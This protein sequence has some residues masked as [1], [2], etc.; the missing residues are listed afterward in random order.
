MNKK[1]LSFITAL[2]F[3]FACFPCG[4]GAA[5]TIS[6]YD[7]DYA[8]SAFVLKSIC[9]DFP[10]ENGE[11]TTRAEFVAAVSMVLNMPNKTV[12]QTGF[13]D[14]GA[15]NAYASHISYARDLGL[16]SSVDLFYPESP[17]TYE[18][19]IKIVMT[20]CGY[21][22][23]AEVMGGYPAGYLRCA[24]EAGIG[25]GLK[26]S[27]TETLSHAT[28]T[29]LIFEMAVTDMVEMSSFGDSIDY[30]VT[31]GKNILSVYHGIYIAEGV[32]S[33][34]EFTGIR[35]IGSA[36]PEGF[37]TVDGVNFKGEGYT[38]LLGKNVRIFYKD[39]TKN[40]IVCGY[41]CN[42]KE[43]KYTSDDS[44]TLTSNN[45]KVST[46]ESLKDIEFKLESDYA[47]IYNGK[48]YSTSAPQNYVNPSS[49]SVI[50]IDN[51]DNGKIDV[52]SVRDVVYGVV[53]STNDLEEKIYDKYKRN[54]TFDLSGMEYT[55]K[56]ADG[57][58]LEM[59]DLEA[60]NIL[61]YVISADNKLCEIIR[62][63][64][65]VGGVLE[66]VTSDNKIIV[67][68]NE[69][70]LSLY[71]TENIKALSQI[72]MGSEVVLDLGEANIVCYVSEFADK[73]KYG[74]FVGAGTDGGLGSNPK[75][76]IFGEDGNMQELNLAQKVKIDGT[77]K[78]QTEALTILDAIE[79]KPVLM[80]VVK[81]SLNAKGEVN[82]VY[83]A[84]ENTEGTKVFLTRTQSESQPV[85][86]DDNTKHGYSGAEGKLV[87]KNGV[88]YPYFTMASDCVILKVPSDEESR[89]VQKHYSLASESD[90]KSFSQANGDSIECYGYDVDIDGASLILW[91]SDQGGASNVAEETANVIVEK[92]T[93][94]SSP[95][96]EDCY[97]L[98]L[99]AEGTADKYYS[100][101]DS[102]AVVSAMKPGDIVQVSYN[103]DK[104]ITAANINF[105]WQT[106]EVTGNAQ[107]PQ[108]YNGARVGLAAGYVYN[109]SGSTGMIVRNK[110][111]TEIAN[112]TTA[113]AHTDMFPVSLNRGKTYFVKFNYDRQ[114]GLVLDAVVHTENG[115]SSIESF[116]NAGTD[117]DYIVQRARF[118]DVSYTIVY[119]N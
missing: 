105:K 51:N 93:R 78:T 48:S 69:Y 83:Q 79:L 101:T 106:K 111:I 33:A 68:G 61:G 56:D 25:K 77:A 36:C 4:A 117:A 16:I 55:I 107:A 30:T 38:G 12:S 75:V 63:S 89:Y 87:Y 103:A 86:F 9:P 27:G 45:I 59:T 91:P 95:D 81:Y 115:T 24:N 2:I 8:N 18:Q 62:Y 96:G 85:L 39:N 47:F 73:V 49:G 6:V 46:N 20:A 58:P 15:D 70:E 54:G 28:A 110:T 44:L 19:A 114:T 53:G 108:G 10:L 92:V 29:E 41:E 21:G 3:V 100:T 112:A 35:S 64:E 90:I 104:E 14:V 52:I 17:I 118:H 116:Y 5:P 22:V 82:S 88:F 94:G 76:M 109:F 50:L 57:T 65:K 13:S 23:K 31:K 98:T 37:V 72:K 40:E 26:L 99:F 7:D 102:E 71:Y 113:F 74:F 43:Y 119:T 97:V 11:V 1:I 80:R 67:G 34:N 66:G 60:D 32:V 84:K 42:N